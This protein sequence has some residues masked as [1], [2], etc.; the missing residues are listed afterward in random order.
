MV[1]RK[2]KDRKKSIYIETQQFGIV[3][4]VSMIKL[5]TAGNLS[6]DRVQDLFVSSIILIVA[7]VP[8]GLPTIVAMSLALNMIKLAGENALI[9][10]ISAT[11][12]S[13]AISVICS[14]KT[15]TLTENKM[16]V[17]SVCVN[18]FCMKLQLVVNVLLS[19][20]EE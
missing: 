12:T 13:G 1:G 16:K 11:E 20:T 6:F 3:F 15:G 7:A 5:A 19:S 17:I 14:D 4:I 8:E 9:K 10:K 18:E 2:I